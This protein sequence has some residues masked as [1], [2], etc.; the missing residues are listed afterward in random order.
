MKCKLDFCD[1][2]DTL[3][4]IKCDVVATFAANLTIQIQRLNISYSLQRPLLNL[5]NN[6]NNKY[7]KLNYKPHVYK[8]QNPRMD[9]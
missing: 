1:K 5:Y 7:N 8:P 6:Y 3:S 4:L 9:P 2:F